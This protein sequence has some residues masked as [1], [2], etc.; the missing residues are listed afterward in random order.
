MTEYFITK[1]GDR[2]DIQKPDSYFQERQVLID[3]R[4]EVYIDKDSFWG[5]RVM[6]ISSS[7][8]IINGE[9]GDIA[10]KRVIVKKNAWICSGAILYNCVV[11]E[12]SIVSIGSVVKN[13]VIP[14]NTA[15]EGNPAK[16]VAELR[17]GRWHGVYT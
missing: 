17:E 11:G 10:L 5:F 4:G 6:V 15:V 9:F 7:H 2:V 16:I 3:R 8:E 14:D 13:M 1:M 12:N